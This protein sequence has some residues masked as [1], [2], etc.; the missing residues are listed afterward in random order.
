MDQSN[1]S[2][3]HL[4]VGS[5]N[6]HEIYKYLHINHT[7]L[8]TTLTP[9]G[10]DHMHEQQDPLEA[11]KHQLTFNDKQLLGTNDEIMTEY[12]HFKMELRFNN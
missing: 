11:S 3:L 10:S 2:I 8:M 5:S 12:S 9:S 7:P 6:N 4:N 1:G